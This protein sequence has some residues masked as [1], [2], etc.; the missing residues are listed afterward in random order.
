MAKRQEL[1][2]S[3]G[4]SKKRPTS[5]IKYIDLEIEYI[6]LEEDDLSEVQ[7]VTGVDHSVSH[8]SSPSTILTFGIIQE[9]FTDA[10]MQYLRALD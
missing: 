8:G 6:D 4:I 5:N 9:F 7:E 3:A 10:C 2:P 1:Q